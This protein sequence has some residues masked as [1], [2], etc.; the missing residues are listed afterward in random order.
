MNINKNTSDFTQKNIAAAIQLWNRAAVSVLDIRHNLIS[1]EEPLLRYRM[2]AGTFVY[3]WGKAE[4]LLNDT[5]YS[6]ERFGLFHGGKGTELS[7]QPVEGWL[8]YYMV[9]YKAIEPSVHKKEYF[10]LLEQVN[11]FRQQYGFAPGNPLFFAEQLRSMYEKWNGPAPINLFYGKS[12]FY[13]LVYE[14]YEELN[15]GKVSM[16]EPDMI[17]LARKY[18]DEHYSEAVSI[19]S[20]REVLGISNSHFHRLFTART[21]KSPQEYLIHRRLMATKQYL[22]Q[23]DCT[24]R[25]IAAKCG[26][27]DELSLMRL[28]RR[29]EHMS[30]T[31]YRD[32]CAYEMG[33]P[34]IDN[35]L[36]SPYNKESQVSLDEL[37]G[38]G[39]TFMFRQIRNKGVMAAALALMLLMTGCSTSP[40]NN[41][42]NSAPAT[43]VTATISETKPAEEGT[44]TVSTSLGEVEV[45]A[46][47]KRVV[48][49]YL[50]G[51]VV[52][53]GIT[54]VGVSDVYE[55]AAF[56]ELVADSVGLGWFPEWEEESVMELNPDLILVISK[57]DVE[58]FSKIA[59]TIFVPYGDM[60]QDERVTF[61]GEI[62]NKQEEAAEAINTY[63][64]SLKEAKAKLSEAGFDNYTVSVFE[65]GS[66]ATMSIRGDQFGT[67]SI[68]YKELGLGAP[69]AVKTNVIDKNS[70]GEQVSFEVL[71]DYSG[72]FIIRNTYEGMADLSEDPIWNSIPAVAN[73]RVIG[74]EFGLSYYPDI[75]SAT[76]QLNH[77]TEELLRTVN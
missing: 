56:S 58:R 13:Q 12:A 30:T 63:D 65:G 10:R 24:L 52:T 50:M 64:K 33:Y 40:A 73:D 15:R 61:M 28:F 23:T 32:I 2:P 76:A 7:I 68:L 48:V 62:L 39:A 69:E 70:G 42:D 72:D 16:F 21:G 77:V 53:L 38:K 3:A 26:F 5:A 20:M 31:E 74:I 66:D 8:E 71:A 43:T 49:Q 54:P 9:L 22:S 29:H 60:T 47:P 55:G 1:P 36:P 11:P 51:D 67:G 17:A 75:L 46:N 41:G 45:P 19:Q 25:E 37:K 4:L 57:D 18:F 14:V 44:R 35:L 6:V 27:S 59:P 34:S